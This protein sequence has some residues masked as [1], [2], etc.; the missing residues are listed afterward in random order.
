MLFLLWVDLLLVLRQVTQNLGDVW[1]IK[2][3]SNMQ[4]LFNCSLWKLKKIKIIKRYLVAATKNATGKMRRA[5][6]NATGKMRRAKC[7]GP[8]H[9]PVRADV[10]RG[11]GI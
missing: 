5:K 11:G 10:S 6:T 2:S 8:C 3:A 1:V 9:H 4:T 7:D